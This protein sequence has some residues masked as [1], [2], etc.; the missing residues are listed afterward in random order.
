MKDELKQYYAIVNDW[1]N[2]IDEYHSDL[3]VMEETIEKLIDTSNKM[4]V[5]L[6]PPEGSNTPKVVMNEKLVQRLV[7][8]CCGL[9]YLP[10]ITQRL[11]GTLRSL[12][13]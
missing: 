10:E 13:K 12:V 3:F 7:D 11:H 9:A 2:A 6:N 8:R 1:I 5:M 4:F